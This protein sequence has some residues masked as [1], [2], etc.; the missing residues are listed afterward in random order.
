MTT[1][2]PGST[3]PCSSVTL[4]L[5]SD[6]PCCASADVA[7]RSAAITHPTVDLCICRLR[8]ACGDESENDCG[9]RVGRGGVPD[10]AIASRTPRDECGDLTSVRNADQ[11][12]SGL[13]KKL[14]ILPNDQSST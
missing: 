4:P 1:V 11:R 12:Q 5:N 9:A 3:A 8:S 2:T 7:T 10:A 14:K 6:V 13:I